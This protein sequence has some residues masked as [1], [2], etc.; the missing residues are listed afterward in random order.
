MD[1]NTKGFS[2]IAQL[3]ILLGLVGAG[4]VLAS[5]ISA[6]I[7][8]S[9][10]GVPLEKISTIDKTNPNYISALKIVQVIATCISFLLPAWIFSK[11]CYKKPS[12]FLGTGHK[13]SI[14]QLGLTFFIVIGCIF[15]LGALVYVNKLI[16]LPASWETSFEKM[17]QL[18]NT[19]VMNLAKMKTTT[20]LLISLFVMAVLPALTEEFIFRGC[21]QN[22]LIGLTKKAWIGIILTSILF[23]LIH[24]S[25]S[26]FLSRAFLGMVLGLLYYYS[27]SIW[28]SIIGHSLF[29]G[30][31]ITL[32]YFYA[33]FMDKYDGNI[34]SHVSLVN[35]IGL[36]ATISL[37]YILYKQYRHKRST[38][39]L[40]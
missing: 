9:Y 2:Y 22:I 15:S 34:E 5:F 26:G 13:L 7:L 21:L 10:T 11:L 36:A 38:T 31:Q 33:S 27:K 40:I 32:L 25:W 12:V 8:S 6:F 37:L 24:L 1:T 30:I 16:P 35:W 3:G 14:N 20:D 39:S 28:L 19:Q 4:L 17:D 29:N 18:Y 23:S